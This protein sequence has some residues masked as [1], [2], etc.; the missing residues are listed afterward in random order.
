MRYAMCSLVCFL[1]CLTLSGQVF[2]TIAGQVL[3]SSQL[4]VP[5]VSITVLNENTG[6]S[7]RVFSDSS[8][9]YAFP[10]LPIGTYQITVEQ[11]GFTTQE[12]SGIQLQVGGSL[13]VD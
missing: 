3:D 10:S 12:R 8:G 11:T 7:R 2:G 6:A 13:I 5:M 9:H 1:S 4:S